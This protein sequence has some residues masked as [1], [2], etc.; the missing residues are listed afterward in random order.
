MKSEMAR[1]DAMQLDINLLKADALFIE[2]SPRLYD[3]LVS[4]VVTAA[5]ASLVVTRNGEICCG[6]GVERG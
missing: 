1:A 3:V 2:I 6:R 5:I 4:R